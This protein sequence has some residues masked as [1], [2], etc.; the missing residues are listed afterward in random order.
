[1]C[2]HPFV[3]QS[4]GGGLDSCGAG[5]RPGRKAAPFAGQPVRLQ[6]GF[7]H[8]GL[9]KCTAYDSEADD[10]D[11]GG[12]RRCSITG[13]LMFY[14]STRPLR[15]NAPLNYLVVFQVWGMRGSYSS[16][17]RTEGHREP[18]FNFLSASLPL[19]LALV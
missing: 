19:P 4:L 3:G 1:M 7:I 11:G 12:D 6:R 16:E 10:D 9:E 8:S 15:V 17:D 5:H 18:D 13:R 14:P 2:L